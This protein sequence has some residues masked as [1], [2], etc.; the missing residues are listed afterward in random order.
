ML[1]VIATL[2]PHPFQNIAMYFSLED[3]QPQQQL[4]FKTLETVSRAYSPSK[5]IILSYL[6]SRNCNKCFLG[7]L[8]NP[9]N[10]GSHV[11]PIIHLVMTCLFLKCSKNV[12]EHFLTFVEFAGSVNFRKICLQNISELKDTYIVAFIAKLLHCIFSKLDVNCSTTVY[13][14][15]HAIFSLW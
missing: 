2:L 5:M 12:L 11:F 4:T 9:S 7:S 6:P 13:N 14:I 8:H 10:S 1:S 15:S 3:Q